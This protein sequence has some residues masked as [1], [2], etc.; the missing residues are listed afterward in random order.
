M[1]A[2]PRWARLLQDLGLLA[3]CHFLILEYTGREDSHR[4]EW[5]LDRLREL[6]GLIAIEV[7]GYSVMSNRDRRR[8]R[9]RDFQPSADFGPTSGS[10]TQ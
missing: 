8:G 3:L 7:C 1:L 6:A 9:G 10:L 5:I 2:D 4:K